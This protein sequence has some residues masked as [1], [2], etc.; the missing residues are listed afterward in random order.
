MPD[1]GVA[2]SKVSTERRWHEL[3]A[4]RAFAMLL[5]IGLHTSLAFFPSFW[6]VQDEE[7]SFG[8]PFDEFLIG[9][10]GFRMPLFFLLSGFFTAMLW[11]RRGTKPL[12]YHRVRRIVLPLALGLVTIVPAVDWVSERGIE[13]GTEKWAMT[14]AEQGDIWLPIMLNQPEAIH[15]AVTSGAHVDA[16]GD[17]KGTPLHLAAFM[18]LPDVAEVLLENG[19][20]YSL[21]NVHGSTPLEVAVWVG[22]TDVADVFV[23]SGAV[24][25]RADGQQWHDIDWY[26]DGAEFVQ[27]V[28]DLPA[29]DDE[30]GLDS[31]VD[32]FH[33]LWFLW[34]LAW[35]VAGFSLL[36]PLVSRLGHVCTSVDFHRRLL[37]IAFPL[38]LF[39]H[40]QMG[41]G[42]ESR[43]FGPD[44]STG[45]LP[46]A[47]VFLYYAIFFGYGAAAYGARTSDGE[48]LI[49]RLGRY[50]KVGLP[51]SVV[52]VFP[53]AA[54]MTFEGGDWFVAATL[55]VLYAWGMAFGLMGFF[56]HFLSEERYW[57]RYL[58]DASY[59]MYLVHLP[60]VIL[61]QDWIR[62]W[63]TSRLLK[64]L[65]ICWGV[66]G[67][68]LVTYRYLVRYTLVGVLLNGPRT[69][70]G[71]DPT[72]ASS[73]SV[74][75]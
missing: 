29:V 65:T 28:L 52:L 4:L 70:P 7:A 19:A 40:L 45:L 18:G 20:D 31:W 34:F 27:A 50:W 16:R 42:G 59:W 46:A 41:N 30:I 44:T 14:A 12:V 8:G 24:D 22:R 62:E 36:A 47:H 32:Q 63:E 2:Q 9:V 68:L 51:V 38:T 5:G 10:H 26:G 43:T 55:Q 15:V 66:S 71:A 21:K 73:N 49:D 25:I 60:L 17:D 57:V 72:V 6:P 75:P 3:D 54:G 39:F 61:A 11:R 1:L 33:H 37:W 53:F 23:E 58:S 13:S 74:L 56:R 35:L 69:R 48:P 64:F 67:V